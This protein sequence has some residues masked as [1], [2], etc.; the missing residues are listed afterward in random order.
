MAKDKKNDASALVETWTL[1]PAATLGSSVRAKGILLEIRARLPSSVR[2]SLDISGSV[3]TLSMPGSSESEFHHASAVVEKS[4]NG[5]ETLPVIPREIEDILTIS[6][7]ERRRW[8]EDGRLPS[9]GTRTV[10]LRGRA[11]QITFHVFEARMVEELLDR[12]TVKEWREEDATAAAEHRRRA[13]YRAKLTRSLKKDGKAT[14]ASR[15]VTEDVEANLRGW[16]EFG[17]DGLLR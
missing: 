17:R 5:I 12:A 6:T 11:R 2:K 8:L 15:D 16:E 1:L 14:A 13:A 9:A 10:K 4:L 7:T 3:L